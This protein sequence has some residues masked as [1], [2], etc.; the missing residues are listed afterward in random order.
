MGHLIQKF[1]LMLGGTTIW[2]YVN[3]LNIVFS[4]NY[5][6]HIGNYLYEEYEFPKVNGVSSNKLNF[7]TGILTFVL[8][9][10]LIEYYN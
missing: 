3:F 7:I 2:L 10:T 9:I 8:I 5:K 4:K 6:S 1:I